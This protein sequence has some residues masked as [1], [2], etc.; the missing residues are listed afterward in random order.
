MKPEPAEIIDGVDID[1]EAG[2]AEPEARL[3]CP[4]CGTADFVKRLLF[5]T[6]CANP[7]HL[8]KSGEPPINTVLEFRQCVEHGVKDTCIRTVFEEAGD[9]S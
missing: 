4:L 2:P 5:F 3:T 9:P 6:Y 1:V 7:V 8:H